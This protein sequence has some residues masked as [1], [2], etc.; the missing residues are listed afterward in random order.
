M[1]L[2]LCVIGGIFIVALAIVLGVI[3]ILERCKEDPEQ[4]TY[5]DR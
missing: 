2:G 1:M 5:N 3:A 4:E